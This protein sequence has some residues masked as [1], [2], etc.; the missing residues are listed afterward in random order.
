MEM[1]AMETRLAT[2][3]LIA[4]SNGI[5][6][7]TRGVM[8]SLVSWEKFCC[9]VTVEDSLVVLAI[10]WTTPNSVPRKGCTLVVMFTS[11][12]KP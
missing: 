10:S 6:L 12:G 8:L 1:F 2:N 9:R 3:L 5:K 7:S 4:V 11:L